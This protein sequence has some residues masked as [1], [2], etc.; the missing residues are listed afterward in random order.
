MPFKLLTVRSTGYE[1]K[2]YI[3]KGSV[4]LA[5]I[6]TVLFPADGNTLVKFPSIN[7]EIFSMLR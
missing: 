1:L 4:I 5:I 3:P 2:S 7:V 6:F